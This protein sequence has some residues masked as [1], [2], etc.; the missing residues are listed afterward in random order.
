MKM[1]WKRSTEQRD[2]PRLRNREGSRFGKE[3]GG[4]PFLALPSAKYCVLS[5]SQRIYYC[6]YLSNVNNSKL[7]KI[8]LYIV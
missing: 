3:E 1:G 8:L 6:N 7:T 4:E 5:A 2:R